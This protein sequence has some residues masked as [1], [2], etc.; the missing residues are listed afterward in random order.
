VEDGLMDGIWPMRIM[1]YFLG[2]C[3]CFLFKPKPLIQL[4]T[5]HMGQIILSEP[6]IIIIWRHDGMNE[7]DIGW[8][9]GCG[10]NQ[11]FGLEVGQMWLIS[12]HVLP[13]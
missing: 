8:R 3:G 7:Q 1:P 11:D 12:V 6:S 9:N 13:T 5:I 10:A 4:S 2:K